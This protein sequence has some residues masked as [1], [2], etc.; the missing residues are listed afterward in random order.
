MYLTYPQSQIYISDDTIGN[1]HF[2][3]GVKMI[4]KL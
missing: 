3:A 4:F 1:V 2:P